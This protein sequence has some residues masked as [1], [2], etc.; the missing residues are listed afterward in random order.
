MNRSC[1]P[2]LW[3]YAYPLADQ[4]VVGGALAPP[5][6][7]VP[8]LPAG[9]TDLFCLRE[10]AFLSSLRREGESCRVEIALIKAN[11]SCL[12]MMLR[13]ELLYTTQDTGLSMRPAA[14]RAGATEPV[15]TSLRVRCPK[16]EESTT[17]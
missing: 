5:P 13:Q 12:S 15:R 4:M 8:R 16:I 6:D 2:A 9:T 1:L 10:K 3:L 7:V 14:V 17:Q 11:S